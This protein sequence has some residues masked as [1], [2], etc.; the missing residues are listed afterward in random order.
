[1]RFILISLLALF[2]AGP[3]FAD[4]DRECQVISNAID[5]TEAGATDDYINLADGSFS[6]TVADEDEFIVPT[7]VKVWGL[8]VTVDVAPTA[9]DTWAI[10]IVDDG[11]ATGVTCSITGAS[12]VSCN[13]FSNVASV[14]SGSD[15]TVLVDSSTGLADPAAAAEIRF[16]FC[17]SQ[18]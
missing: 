2:I 10:T 5:P 15:L 12:D 4:S 18:R 9:D 16:G 7:N 8:A 14:A 3:A 11:V 1:M 17:I 13:D 6:A